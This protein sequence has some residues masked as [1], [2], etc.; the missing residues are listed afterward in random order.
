MLETSNLARKYTQVWRFRIYTFQYQGSLN[1]ADVSIFFAKNQHF[2]AFTKY[3][4]KQCESCVWN[5]LVLF[6]VLEDKRLLVMKIQFYRLCVWNP[7][8]GLLQ[9]DQKLKK[10]AE[11]S[12]FFDMTLSSNF[13]DVALFVLSSL[14]TDPSFMSISSLVLEL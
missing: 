10:I 13:S 12:Q 3:S 7:A 9:I 11:T 2:L 8:F 4:I 1:F 14:D 5:F 6:S